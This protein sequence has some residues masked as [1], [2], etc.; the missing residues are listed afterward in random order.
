MSTPIQGL[1]HVTA[2]SH[3]AQRNYDFYAKAL[4]LRFVKRT[5]NFDD[6]S[7]YHLYYGDAVGHPGTV[8]TFFPWEGIRPGRVGA[9]QVSITHFAVPPGSLDFWQQRL[10]GRGAQ[11][12]AREAAF[13]EN[14][15]RFRDPDG[16]LIALVETTDPRIPW[17]N[18]EIDAAVAVR[19][20]HGVTLALHSGVPTGQIL[21]ELLGYERVASEAVAGGEGQLVRYHMPAAPGAAVVDLHIDPQLPRGIDGAGTV[22]HVAFA[23]PDRAAQAV[24]RERFTGV[25]LGVTPAIDRDYFWAIYCRTPEGVLFEVATAEPGFTVDEPVESL[26]G[27][28][29]L[30]RQHEPRREQIEAQLP[31][32]V[33]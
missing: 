14:R 10:T 9:G 12:I 6:P 24:I 13:G 25:G 18:P 31:P 11:L 15:A 20:F 16:L 7:A 5:V 28:L 33:L 8:M 3:D 30:P 26:G 4:G 2:I 32:L 21:T 29:R 17:T 27:A 23:V 19:G 1:H 22:H